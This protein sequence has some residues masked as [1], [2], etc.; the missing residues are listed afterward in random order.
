MLSMNSLSLS[1]KD[2]RWKAGVGSFFRSAIFSVDRLLRH[3]QGI[4]GYLHSDRDLLRIAVREWEGGLTAIQG[5]TVANGAAVIELHLW[6]ERIAGLGTL[7]PGLGWGTRLCR[8]VE[9][10]FALLAGRMEADSRLAGCIAIRAEIVF[11]DKRTAAKFIRIAAR[12]GLLCKPDVPPP[13]FGRSF[14][15]LALVWASNPRS[16]AGKRLRPGCAV[17]WISMQCFRRRY[18]GGVSSNDA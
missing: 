6:N 13:G 8:H 3:K 9:H 11:P 17:F 7:G 10:S 18:A 1:A 15:A 4:I 5:A 16:L 14:L 2:I 12:F